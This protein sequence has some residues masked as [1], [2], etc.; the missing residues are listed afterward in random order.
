MSHTI[1]TPQIRH[2]L[3]EDHISASR[4]AFSPGSGYEMVGPW[5]RSVKRSI[6][7]IGSCLGLLCLAPL[8]VVIALLIRL[9]SK[10]PVLFRQKRMGQGGRVFWCWKFRTMVVDAEAQ[11]KK[12]EH[13]NESEGGVLFKIKQDPRITRLGSVLRRSSLDELPQLVNVLRGQMSLVGPR[14]LQIRDC[15][16]LEQADPN[17]YRSRLA[18]PQGLTGLWQ[19]GGR[20]DTSFER[21]V[22]LDLVY[23]SQWSLSLDLKILVSTVSVVLTAKGAC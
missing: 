7:L 14:P 16:L 12:L 10:G 4:P 18:V 17:G 15:E 1:G 11:L 3:A 21:M 22:A 8:L 6:D 13:L 5:R 20:S 9:E 2:H 23:A 19:V